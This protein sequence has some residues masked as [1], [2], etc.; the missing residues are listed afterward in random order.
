MRAAPR[1]CC[2]PCGKPVAFD[3]SLQVVI[4]ILVRVQLRAVRRQ[5][6]HLQPLLG[7]AA[8][9]ACTVE[10]VR[11]SRSTIR[12]TFPVVL[13]NSRCKNTQEQGCG[14]GNLR[15]GHKPH[16]APVGDR[17]DLVLRETRGPGTSSVAGSPRGAQPSA[18]W[19]VCRHADL[20][21][22]VDFGSLLFGAGR[23][24][25]VRF[26]QPLP[27]LLG[28]L[29]SSM[30]AWPLGREAPAFPDTGRRSAPRVRGCIPCGPGRA[31]ARRVHKGAAMPNS[32]G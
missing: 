26:L 27:H 8:T 18:G 19:W 24:G 32:S 28:V 29:V 6:K 4:Q 23:D 5:I 15:V 13:R 11:R 22:R 1:S 20:V 2:Q 16:L 10:S 21:A 12:N 17:R 9:H 3:P 30:A 25:R 14:H 7:G 31:T